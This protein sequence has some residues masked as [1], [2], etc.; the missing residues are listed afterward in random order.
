MMEI[1]KDLF[2]PYTLAHGA[3]GWGLAKV[4]VSFTW[5][6]LIAVGWEIVEPVL[7]E[8]YPDYFPNPSRDSSFNKFTDI[9]AWMIGYSL[10][11]DS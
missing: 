6:F 10:G 8:N 2:D 5:S 1:N 4:G 7:K 3:I 11:R 9:G